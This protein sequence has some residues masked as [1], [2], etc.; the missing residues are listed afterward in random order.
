MAYSEGLFLALVAGML[1]PRTAGL[2][3]R[4]PARLAASLTRPT[5]AAAALAP[6]G[7]RGAGGPRAGQLASRSPPPRWRWPG[8]P[9]YLGWVAW[10]VGD[11]SAWFRIQTAG[12]GTSFDFGA[13]TCDFLAR[14]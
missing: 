2:V 5:G 12:W 14:R 1:S 7:R 9:L 13:S 4:R 11:L 6:G 8:C 3:G 10:R